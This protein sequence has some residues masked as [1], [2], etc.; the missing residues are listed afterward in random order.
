MVVRMRHT[1]GHS[2]NRRSHHALKNRAIT[3]SP[4]GTAH[5]RHRVLLEGGTYRGR[6]LINTKAA[7]A[8]RRAAKVKREGKIE[9]PAKEEKPAKKEKAV[10]PA[11]VAKKKESKDA[12]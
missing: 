4:E 12:K 6:T 1:K 8:E 11:K 7:R 3:T 5:L 10:K 9:K 2:A